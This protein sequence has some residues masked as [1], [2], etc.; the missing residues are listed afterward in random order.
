MIK[1]SDLQSHPSIPEYHAQNIDTSTLLDTIVELLNEKLT[2]YRLPVKI[3]YDEIKSGSV[4][5]P[6]IQKCIVI[7]NSEKSYYKYCITT[8]SQGAITFITTLVFGYS[9]I[10]VDMA[11]MEQI[12]NGGLVVKGFGK[13]FGGSKQ[14]KI[15]EE[16]DYYSILNHC[17]L[18]VLED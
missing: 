7:E 2:T 4:F 12:E 9:S 13:L 11:L 8:R 15:Q 17:L 1:F 3:Y 10:G 6:I 16:T 5:K 18:S 14:Q